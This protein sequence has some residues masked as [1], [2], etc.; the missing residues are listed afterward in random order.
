MMNKTKVFGSI[1]LIGILGF[2]LY[3]I[4]SFA[5]NGFFKFA[6][7]DDDDL[8]KYANNNLLM[9]AEASLYKEECG[10]CHIAYPAGLLPP[11]SWTNMMQTLEDHFAENAELDEA[12]RKT[13]T[14]YLVTMSTPKDGEYRKF[15]RNMSENDTPERITETAYFIHEHDEIPQRFI[16]ENDK[17]KSLSQCDSCHKGAENGHFDEHQVYIPGIGRWDD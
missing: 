17:V 10:S 6:D 8:Y 12:T 9:S 14:Q 15:L 4:S 11:A 3:G 7:D 1:M 16:T 13:V 5:S 2:G